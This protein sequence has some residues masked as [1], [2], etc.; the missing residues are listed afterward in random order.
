MSK[1]IQAH[2]LLVHRNFQRNENRSKIYIPNV[3]FFFFFS[4]DINAAL[5]FQSISGFL[6][7]FFMWKVIENQK[8][9]RLKNSNVRKSEKTNS[10]TQKRE[11]LWRLIATGMENFFLKSNLSLCLCLSGQLIISLRYSPGITKACFATYVN[12]EIYT[13]KKKINK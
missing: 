8:M 13:Q 7:F 4:P 10:D 11:S 3:N 6:L 2:V 12:C 1:S 5:D 9:E